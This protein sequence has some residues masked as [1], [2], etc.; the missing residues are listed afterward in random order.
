[1]VYIDG[2]P[3][4]SYVPGGALDRGW[5]RVLADAA[6]LDTRAL[7]A[8]LQ[9]W[10]A[11]FTGDEATAKTHLDDALKGLTVSVQATPALA[12]QSRAHAA[13]ARITAT[14]I[15]RHQGAAVD[16]DSATVAQDDQLA[17]EAEAAAAQAR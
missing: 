1:R 3:A 13:D 12:A 14:D 11:A 10:H 15:V 17:D 16:A 9:G 8:E 6:S 4:G 5:R 7:L 2:E